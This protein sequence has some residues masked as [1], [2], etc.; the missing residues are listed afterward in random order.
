[1]SPL[2]NFSFFQHVYQ[3]KLT[4]FPL[5]FNCFYSLNKHLSSSGDSVL[6][7]P[8]KIADNWPITC[9]LVFFFSIVLVIAA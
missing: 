6:E 8:R 3:P 7:E 5:T 1:M 4:V 9:S 2:L